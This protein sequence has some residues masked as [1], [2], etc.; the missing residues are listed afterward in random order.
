MKVNGREITV[1]AVDFDGTLF[2]EEYP[3]IG[4]PIWSTIEYV[5]NLKDQ[6]VQLILHT[7]REGTL[8]QNAVEAC[9]SVGIEFDAVNENITWRID[10]WGQSR[11]IGADLY[12]DDKSINPKDIKGN[13]ISAMIGRDQSYWDTYYKNA[14]FHRCIAAI[15]HGVDPID[16]LKDFCEALSDYID[17]QTLAI[18]KDHVCI[19]TEDRRRGNL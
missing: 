16:I 3:E 17:E 11:K 10:H 7:N 1:A 5:R 15:D 8:L 6:G 2:V 4:R 13:F 14:H 12:I 19:T 9:R 18:L